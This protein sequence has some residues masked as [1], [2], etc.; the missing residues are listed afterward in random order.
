M[1]MNKAFYLKKENRQPKWHII[2]A[3]GKVLGRMATQIADIL[4]GKNKPYY[5][6]HTDCGDYVVVINADKVHMTGNKWKDKE[7]VSYSGWMSGKKVCHAQDMLKKHPTKIV[8]LAVRRMLPKN[9]LNA[10]IYR[11]LKVY[12]GAEHPHKAQITV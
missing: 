6:P 12:A 10:D 5:T 1:V 9:T 7:Y 11:K 4:R 3:Q 8:E 2:D